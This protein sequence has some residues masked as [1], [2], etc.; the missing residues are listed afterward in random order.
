MTNARRALW[1][2][3]LVG[4]ACGS[5]PDRAVP[6][7]Y[8]SRSLAE[9]AATADPLGWLVRVRGLEG[10]PPPPGSEHQIRDHAIAHGYLYFTGYWE[11]LYRTSL[12]GGPIEV[13]E[14][15]PQNQF[16]PVAASRLGV[17]WLNVMFDDRDYPYIR[18]QHKPTAD[19]PPRTLLTGQL[20]AYGT[21]GSE[22]FQATDA[23][24]FFHA[25]PNGQ[26]P[27]SAVL[28]VSPDAGGARE[29]L[30]L[31]EELRTPTWAVDD[32][33]L[34]F[35]ADRRS[36]RERPE[37]FRVPIEGGQP[38][39]VATLPGLADVR[40]IDTDHVYV[41]SDKVAWKISKQ[42]GEASVLHEAVSE[43]F[44]GWTLQVD[45][46]YVYLIET[47]RQDRTRFLAVPKAGGPARVL[48]QDASTRF[49][50]KMEQD[51]G[52]LYLLRS[53]SEILVLRKPAP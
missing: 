21:N 1:L 26:R 49:V 9:A 15:G 18:L 20:G 28:R 10:E 31:S 12:A 7:A 16:E 27:P 43:A 47:G 41:A 17:F 46:R 50:A 48:G 38:Q 37:L 13:V 3:L 39:A 8:V 33:H 30:P 53:S 29:I 24:L 4:P 44:L 22:Q 40:G 19:A 11:G 52:H 14:S 2:L 25:G 45:E 36:Q 5:E 42:N 23:G 35:T 32:V 34:Y 51:E 6:A